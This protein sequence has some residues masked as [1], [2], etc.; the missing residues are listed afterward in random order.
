MFNIGDFAVYPGQGVGVIESIEKKEIMGNDKPFYIMKIMGN[1]MKIMIPVDLEDS[2]GLRKVIHKNDISNIYEVLR[3]KDV[4]IDKRTWNKRHKEYLEKIKT[5]SVLEIARVLRALLV[6]KPDKNLSFV[7]QRI[8]ETAKN[9][10]ITE[11][12]VASNI[13][14]AKIEKD[15]DKLLTLQ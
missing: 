6:L 12:S 7:E 1:H 8:M 10:L 4:T 14:E 3:C 13:E 9:L 5:G 11:I 2:V 15:L